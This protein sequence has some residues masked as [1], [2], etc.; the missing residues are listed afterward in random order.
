MG[1]A[2]F[3][4]NASKTTAL[5]PPPGLWL[6]LCPG[7]LRHLS[8]SAALQ[9]SWETLLQATIFLK[10]RNLEQ[11]LE[12]EE[13]WRFGECLVRVASKPQTV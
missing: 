5:L 2:A 10:K 3:C 11:L 7:M 12:T 9:A 8:V 13:L 4:S 6:V 1:S